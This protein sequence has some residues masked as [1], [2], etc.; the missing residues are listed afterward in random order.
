MRILK[1]KLTTLCLGL[2]PLILLSG[3]WSSHE[4]NNR[5]FV[6]MMLID[7]AEDG[8]TELTLAFILPNRMIPGMTGGGG[9]PK[10]EPFTFVTHKAENISQALSKI[11]VD[12]SRAITFGHT[13]II[14]IGE[15]F[16]R[17]GV[18]PIL[19]FVERQTAF[20]LSSNIFVTQG[21]V[22]QVTKTPLVFEQF[23]SVI[24]T[25]Y[26]RLHFTLDT[27]VKDV[28]I[29]DY[30]GGDIL[31]PLL[32]FTKHPE[33]E[34]EN[35]KKDLWMGT[36][37]AAII[38]GAKMVSPTLNS[39]ELRGALW[40]SSQIKSSIISVPSPT[41]GKEISCVMQNISTNFKPILKNGELS[42][43]IKSNAKAFIL[44]TKSAIDLSE[45]ELLLQIEKNLNESV[46]KNMES[47][48]NKTKK[49][50]SDAFLM[51]NYVDWRYPKI[52]SELKPRWKDY[53]STRLPIDVSVNIDLDRTGGS[54]R[55]I[56]LENQT[57]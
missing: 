34:L 9:A 49:A 30:K 36:D 28:I 44:D 14:I 52:W 41:D 4:I 10:G 8:Q 6:T 23:L 7:L 15:K 54:Y 18:T 37:G 31:M 40:I 43:Q 47:V 16:A 45:G 13:Q 57:K 50:K 48:I 11:S 39:D 56:T 53:Y 42:F 33:I 35:P 55:S 38:S 51:S 20:H 5:S 46:K 25:K 24:L 21:D 1:K 26:I 32:S 3:C 2:L 27:T 29:A 22:L 19:E 12:L 17:Q